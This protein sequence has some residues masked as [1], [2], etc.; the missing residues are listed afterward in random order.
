MELSEA[1]VFVELRHHEA[2]LRV[3]DVAMAIA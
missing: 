1:N 3:S 2:P